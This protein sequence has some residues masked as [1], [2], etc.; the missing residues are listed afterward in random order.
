MSTDTELRALCVKA[1]LAGMKKGVV[2]TVDQDAH[3]TALG[4]PSVSTTH[5]LIYTTTTTLMLL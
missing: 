2:T 5:I 3:L 4:T 1:T